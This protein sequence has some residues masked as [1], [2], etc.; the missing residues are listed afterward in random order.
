MWSR[1]LKSKTEFTVECNS[2]LVSCSYFMQVKKKNPNYIH[3][4]PIK[5]QKQCGVFS[6]IISLNTQNNLVK[7]VIIIQPPF[8]QMRKEGIKKLA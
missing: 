4:L 6:Y 8:K 1:Q 2:R 7:V 3:L 5:W